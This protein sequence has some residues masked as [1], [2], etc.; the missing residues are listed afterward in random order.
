[1]INTAALPRPVGPVPP[2]GEDPSS[3]LHSKRPLSV[4]DVLVLF[5]SLA[6]VVILVLLYFNEKKNP[7]LLQPG[8]EVFLTFF[9]LS[10]LGMFFLKSDWF[11]NK[12]ILSIIFVADTLFITAG[13]YLSGAGETNLL[14]I[15]FMTIFISALSQDVKSVF[16]VAV[17]ACV[18]Y[19]FLQYQT[20]GTFISSDTGFLVRFPFLLVA[21]A[22]SGFMA[23]ETKKNMEEKAHLLNLNQ[24]L[25]D[26]ADVSSQK[27]ME[28]NRNLKSLLEYHHCILSSLQTG[29]IVVRNDGK[30]RTFNAGCRKITGLVEAEMADKKLR[31]FPV[32]LKSVAQALERTLAEGKSFIQEHM[33]LKTV[34]KEIVPVTLETSVLRAGNGNVIG[35]IATIKDVTLLSQMETQLARSERFSAL[36]EMAAGVAH[37]IKNPLNAIMGFSERLSA[38]LVEPKLKKY[39]EVITEEVQRMDTIVN[40]VLEYSRPDKAHKAPVEVHP[41]LEEAVIFLQQKLEN[42]G[43]TVERDYF[44]DLPPVPL[45]I[46]KIRQVLLNLFLNAM[47]AM[48]NGGKLTLRTHLMNGLVPQGADSISEGVIYERLFLQEQMVSISVEDSGCG[49]PKENLGKLFH[50]FFTTKITGTGLGLSVCHKI[51]S[52]H[53]GTLDV[54]SQLGKGSTFRIYLPVEEKK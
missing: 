34:L 50:P 24:C 41:L 48:P 52:S 21:A 44:K 47:Q 45:D 22:M 5:R 37:E 6:F 4:K 16:T 33:E 20:T 39:A 31:D 28:M 11:E 7:T 32:S 53:G 3:I 1:M 46:V 27:L 35:A 51:I 30:V 13:L 17:V 23:M 10:I 26:Q 38:K 9:S 14:L 36:G 19:A 25:A 43:I 12:S 29:I 8:V 54:E 40:E 15:F 18:L 2:A 42:A 49:I